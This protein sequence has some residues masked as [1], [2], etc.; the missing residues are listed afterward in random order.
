MKK[1]LIAI[2]ALLLLL[3]AAAF[4][5]CEEKD[6]VVFPEMKEYVLT[7]GDGAH[8][9]NVP[10][11]EYL[12]YTPASDDGLVWI[13]VRDHGA[14]PDKSAV[15][16]TAALQAAIDAAGAAGNGAVSVKGGTYYTGTLYMKS[17][18]TLYIEK[19]SALKLP[20]Y[21]DYTD[22]EKRTLLNGALI[23]AER[24]DDWAITGPGKLDGNGT[25]YTLDSA[26]PTKNLPQETFNL[27]R[28]VLS[29]RDRLRNR[30]N[31]EFGCHVLYAYDCSDIRI[32]NLI[33]YEPSTWTVKLE[34][35]DGVVVKD[36]VIDNNIYVANSD[37]I[38]V[39]GTSNVEISHC[40]I[41]TGD[42]GIVLK[43]DSG[44]IENVTVRDCE[45]MS[46]A[47]NFKIGTETG[48]DVSDVT[49]T[50]CYFFT[51]EIAGG[52]SGIAIES[53]DGANITNVNVSDIVMNNVPS[54]IL[55]W[56]GCRLDKNKGSKGEVGSIDGVTI[57]NVYAKDVDIASAVVGCEYK[58]EVYSVKN[59]ILDNI[60][61]AYRECGEDLD[62]YNG[63]DV[64]HSNMNGYPEITRVSHAY[65]ISH[66]LST[67]H[68]MPV[69]GLYM[70]NAENVQATAFNV[71]PRSVNT[72]PFTNVGTFDARDGIV[73]CSVTS[74]ADAFDFD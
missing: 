73:S 9:A 16:N 11:D 43:S 28:K 60:N 48:Y 64:L 26:N 2:A 3:S 12:N 67:Y 74:S 8:V 15:E 20:D 39:C 40:F 21:D 44:K 49:V 23:R 36:V 47:N 70:F 35:C 46:L 55:I 42:D 56:L 69:Y 31:E 10:Y 33:V 72:R 38:D 58:N 57:K 7:D 34:L 66:E 50:D 18:V 63:N 45:I 27:K 29:Y 22:A 17:G 53:A 4:S 41:A 13:D 6:G 62:V 19:D 65:L 30:K 52:N 32:E 71:K 25:D 5:A 54:A 24:V 59:V 37:G 1:K 68:D 51:A 14:S 61:I